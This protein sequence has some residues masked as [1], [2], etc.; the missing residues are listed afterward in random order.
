M[1]SIRRLAA[2]MMW[3]GAEAQDAGCGCQGEGGL[4]LSSK[5]W[6]KVQKS[7]EVVIVSNIAAG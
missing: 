2:K 7:V 4:L 3:Y 5:C 6:R 1:G